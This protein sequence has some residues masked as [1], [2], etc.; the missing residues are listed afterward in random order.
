MHAHMCVCACV[1]I[2]VLERWTSKARVHGIDISAL[3]RS[4]CA[5]IFHVN[6]EMHKLVTDI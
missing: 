2:N 4:Q 5:D 6:L 3:Q 1:C